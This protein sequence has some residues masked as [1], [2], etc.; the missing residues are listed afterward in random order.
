M[1]ADNLRQWYKDR[2]F[3]EVKASNSDI[4][5]VIERPEQ[6]Q[7]VIDSHNK[8]LEEISSRDKSMQAMRDYFDSDLVEESFGIQIDS[9]SESDNER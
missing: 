8:L 9:A 5:A 7:R 4:I 6:L 2:D 1:D 3:P